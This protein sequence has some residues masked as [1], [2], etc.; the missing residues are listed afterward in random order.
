MKFQLSFLDILTIQLLTLKVFN[1]I[2]WS[3]ILVFSP[4]I[5]KWGSMLILLLYAKYVVV[6][7]LNNVADEAINIRNILK[8]CRTLREGKI[9]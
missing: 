5:L 2:D 9:K 3:W 4:F 1:V 8:E 7:T 6:K